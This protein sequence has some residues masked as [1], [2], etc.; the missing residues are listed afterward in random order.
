MQLSFDDIFNQVFIHQ[1]EPTSKLLVG[2]IVSLMNKITF[3]HAFHIIDEIGPDFLKTYRK[4]TSQIPENLHEFD[5]LTGIAGDGWGNPAP[6]YENDEY[7]IVKTNQ[8]NPYAEWNRAG[9]Q[10][11]FNEWHVRKSHALMGIQNLYKNQSGA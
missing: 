3:E 1:E 6:A 10:S 2:D 5:G 9:L 11:T 7:A 8:S 4:G